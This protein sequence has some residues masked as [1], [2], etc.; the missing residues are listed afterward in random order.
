MCPHTA[1]P[2][3]DTMHRKAN[4]AAKLLDLLIDGGRQA[5]M[6]ITIPPKRIAVQQSTDVIA[7]ENPILRQALQFIRDNINKPF[8]VAPRQR[9]VIDHSK[10]V[11]P[12]TKACLSTRPPRTMR[13]S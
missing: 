4:E 12:G 8:G 10:G 2:I 7:T 1:K 3:F 9:K 5:P 11:F 6:R 13:S